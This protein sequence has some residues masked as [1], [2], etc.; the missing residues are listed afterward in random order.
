MPAFDAILCDLFETVVLFDPGRLPRLPIG[1]RPLP[2][3]TPLLIPL[4]R[5]HLG[6]VDVDVVQAALM[7]TWARARA[8]GDHKEIPS[9]ERFHWALKELG[10]DEAACQPLALSLATTHTDAVCGSAY[11]PDTHREA[12][13][14]LGER[15]R[16]ALISN[17][18]HAPACRRLLAR[19]G[20]ADRFEV[21]VI[22]DELGLRKPHPR[23]FEAALDAL[24][25]PASACLF[26][27]DSF[28]DDVA[29]ARRCGM[30]AA[31]VN[32]R[33]RPLPEGEAPPDLELRSFADLPAAL[34]L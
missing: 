16:L 29:G 10:M 8:E 14:R 21:I 15:H 13:R 19:E 6:E 7:G 3:T 23:V 30:K 4:L 26:V 32:A 17:F 18:D 12:L 22:S 27:G 9:P 11:L 2:S 25:L 1:G 28:T 24:G 5:P 31:W 34:G 33:G 20:L